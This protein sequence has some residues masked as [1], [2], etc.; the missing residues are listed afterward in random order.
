MPPPK[1]ETIWR[2]AWR[3]TEA[4]RNL[5]RTAW[6]A[7]VGF[8]AVVATDVSDLLG[9]R[10]DAAHTLQNGLVG[11]AVAAVLLPAGEFAYN[12][13]KANERI[14]VERAPLEEVWRYIEADVRVHGP[15]LLCLSGLGRMSPALGEKDLKTKRHIDALE[16]LARAGDIRIQSRHGVGVDAETGEFAPDI[17]FEPVEGRF[18]V[19]VVAVPDT[20]L[21]PQ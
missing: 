11:A 17:W 5:G 16:D 2:R 20:E 9:A 10:P 21:P 1:R 7:F 12:V 4:A 18:G 13:F 3:D 19:K 6:Q 14:D 8:V 15:Q